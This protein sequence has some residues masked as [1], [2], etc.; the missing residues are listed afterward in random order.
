MLIFQSK[1]KLLTEIFDFALPRFCPSCKTKLR[2][3]E[4][5]VCKNCLTQIKLADKSRIEDEFRR[6]FSR[7]KIISDF[8]SPFVFEKDRALQHI[9]HSLKYNQRF[10]SGKFLGKLAAENLAS[11]ISQWEIDFVIPIPLHPLKKAIR[12]YNQA[13]YIAKGIS[14]YSKVPAK[15]NLLKRKKFTQ[16]QTKMNLEERKEN[17]RNAFKTSRA[18]KV[19]GKNLLLVDDVITTGATVT[20]CGRT[21]LEAGANKVYACS[22]AIAD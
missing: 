21:L 11:S 5:V 4:E 9:I 15:S 22:V 2:T 16:S 12:G 20:E 18:K 1:L 6:K 8:N 19:I 3:N 7:E 14:L 13:L 10:Q 17:M